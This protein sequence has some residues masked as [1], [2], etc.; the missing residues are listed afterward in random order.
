MPKGGGIR[1]AQ[2]LRECSPE[3]KILALSG[4][5]D[6]EAVLEMLLSG[7]VG[8]LVKGDNSDL[9]QSIMA[10]G[11]G[12][13][14]ISNEV[15]ASVIGELSGHLERAHVQEES[16]RLRVERIMQVIENR[17]ITMVFQPI[18]DLRAG[19][20]A[21]VEAL[22]RFSGDPSRTPDLWFAEAWDLGLGV[23]LEIVAISIALEAAKLCPA[24][25]FVAINASPG[26]ALTT[27][28]SELVGAREGAGKLVIELTEHAAVDDYD[29]LTRSL[30]PI[31]GRGVRVAVDD[32]GAGYASLRHVL[33]LKPD[34]IKLDVSLIA[35][36]DVDPSKL[37]LAKRITSFASDI[38]TRVVAEGI[39]TAPQLDCVM[40]LGVD[41]AQ[42]Y[43]L[44]RPDP[45]LPADFVQRGSTTKA[46][47]L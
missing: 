9:V 36:I 12:E 41:Y 31:R 33:H 43:H 11:R 16:R 29:A 32:A 45:V 47:G 1:A 18:F 26:T 44:G 2:G 10:V 8:Y 42:G 4:A 15:A 3:T 40:E 28:F 7:A 6:R 13:G 27:R 24:G 30:A 34:F 14:A 19:T 20:V 22:A 17:E 37:A 5:S 39:E 25:L 46:L 35:G 21:G 23:E 38:G